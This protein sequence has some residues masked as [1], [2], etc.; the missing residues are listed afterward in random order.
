M[1]LNSNE[2]KVLKIINDVYKDFF[3]EENKKLNVNPNL[4]FFATRYAL[5]REQIKA[6]ISEEIGIQ[7]MQYFARNEQL[8]IAAFFGLKGICDPS[9]VYIKN[10]RVFFALYGYFVV[11]DEFPAVNLNNYEKSLEHF[12]RLA[13]SYKARTYSAIVIETVL[14]SYN[15]FANVYFEYHDKTIKSEFIN[16]IFMCKEFIK[17]HEK[18]MLSAI[19]N[20][21]ENTTKKLSNSVNKNK[22]ITLYR[23]FEIANTKNVRFN[24]VK[25]SNPECYLQDAG[26]S[27]CYTLNKNVAYKFAT[28]KF[29]NHDE[30]NVSYEDRISNVKFLLSKSVDI[31]NEMMSKC[32]RRVYVAKYEVDIDDV[33][34]DWCYS[35]ESEVIVLPKNAKLIE[36]RP[37]R[38]T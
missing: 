29:V 37:V 22:K 20:I 14:F 26:R 10:A 38:Y 9:H 4:M 16:L 25:K 24:R 21:H 8:H 1:N 17:H 34:T 27:I 23:G 35:V 3:N 18:K 12:N 7:A 33:V 2:I 6:T 11:R 13:L 15:E 5:L 30:F 36:Y 31:D 32:D 28:H 19:S